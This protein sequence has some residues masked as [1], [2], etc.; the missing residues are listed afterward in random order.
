MD[1]NASIGQV[2]AKSGEHLCDFV[3]VNTANLTL[4]RRDSYM[5]HMKSGIKPDTLAALRTAPL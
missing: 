2:M 3:S 4:I 5:S 1:F